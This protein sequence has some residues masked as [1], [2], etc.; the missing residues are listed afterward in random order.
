MSDEA[1]VILAIVT[2]AI[3]GHQVYR[4]A[5][6][7]VSV[8][9]ELVPPEVRESSHAVANEAMVVRHHLRQVAK[10]D[11]PLAEMVKRI[12]DSK[13]DRHHNARN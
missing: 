7:W 3:V 5:K 10:S 8:R 12:R 1:L 11:D 4:V 6:A 9:D 13:W 2:S